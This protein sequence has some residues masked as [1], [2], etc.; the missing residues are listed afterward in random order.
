MNQWLV[1]KVMPSYPARARQDGV[2]GQVVLQAV[3]G[4][5]GSVTELKHLQGPQILS[6]A[7]M[8]AVR[9]WRFKP[10][11]VDGKPVEVETDIRLN[12]ELPKN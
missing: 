9:R 12:F 10:Y 1:Q 4:K 8:D 6:A 11:A 2:E 3:I 5:D 7:A